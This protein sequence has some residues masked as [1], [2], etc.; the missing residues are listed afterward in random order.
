MPAGTYVRLGVV[1]AGGRAWT[2]GEAVA[3]ARVDAVAR[4]VVDPLREF[5]WSPYAAGGLGGMYDDAERWRVV[6]V[7]ALG[8]EGPALGAVIPAVEIGFG[9]GPRVGIVFRRTMPGRR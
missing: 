8:V 4:F 2:D 1:G 3:S 5:R 6:L 9:G 7:G